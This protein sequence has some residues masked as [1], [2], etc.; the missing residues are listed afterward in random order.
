M[1]ELYFE[2]RRG[3]AIG[4]VIESRSRNPDGIPSHETFEDKTEEYRYPP[5][6]RGLAESIARDIRNECL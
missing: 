5:F 2:R 4:R 6:V 1:V 3:H